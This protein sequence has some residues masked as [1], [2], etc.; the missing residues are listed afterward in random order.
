MSGYRGNSYSIVAPGADKPVRHVR[1]TTVAGALDEPAGQHNGLVKWFMRHVARGVAGRQDLRVKV[2]SAQSDDIVNRVCAEILDANRGSST[3]GTVVHD[4]TERL[5]RGEL[6]DRVETQEFAADLDAYQAALA[7]FG[8]ETFPNY[9]ERVCVNY[10]LSERLAGTVDRI[11]RFGGVYY[12]ADIKTGSKLD[13]QWPKIAVQLA[14]YANADHLITVD[15]EP[16]EMPA[17]SRTDGLVFHL[18]AGKG[19]CDLY[20]VDVAA[21]WEAARLALG[22]RAWRKRRDLASR[23]E[24]DAA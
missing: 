2:A 11:V 1:A 16:E 9:V 21:G 17:V 18:P 10:K 15:G 12:I 6:L 14:I 22:A 5:D 19:C 4:W 8:V 13:Y 3:I 20:R 7:T 23:V 24:V